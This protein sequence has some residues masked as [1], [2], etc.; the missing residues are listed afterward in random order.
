MFP[1]ELVIIGKVLLAGFLG[2]FIGL[3]R[4]LLRKPAGLRTH[5]LVGI[6]SALIVSLAPEMLDFL[7]EDSSIVSADPFKIFEAIV[8]GVSFIGAGVIMRKEGGVKNLTTAASLLVVA[9]IGA[10]VALH[11]FLTAIGVTLIVLITNFGLGKL[12]DRLPKRVKKY[13]ND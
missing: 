13:G 12:E 4:E 7:R 1:E 9:T 8:V 11:A 5:T 6:A 2:A 10:A 3:E